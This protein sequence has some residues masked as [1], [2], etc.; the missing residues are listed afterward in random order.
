MTSACNVE[1]G[2]SPGKAHPETPPKVKLSHI[3]QNLHTEGHVT[4]SI[5]DSNH[6]SIVTGTTILEGIL[7]TV[8]AKSKLHYK[9]SPQKGYAKGK[10]YT[11]AIV[12]VGEQPYAEMNGDNM[13]LTLPDPYPGLIQDTCSHVPCVVVLISGRPL[14][15]EKLVR[16]MDAF[17]A[18]WL[19]GTEGAGVAD[20]L[21]GKHEFQ[22]KLSR[23]WFKRVD[24]LPM[25]IGDE[26]YDPLYPFGYGLKM[27]L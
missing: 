6:T 14:V 18:A 24:Q 26:D 15:M 13:N 16:F 7:Q 9:A 10:N 20:V 5:I 25:N 23:T 11:Y 2:P 12:V 19:P 22:G 21:F 1:A 3:K 4:S 8:S 17:V 27:G